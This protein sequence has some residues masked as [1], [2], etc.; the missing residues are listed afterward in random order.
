MDSIIQTILEQS[1]RKSHKAGSRQQ[2]FE[3][4]KYHAARIQATHA[5]KGAIARLAEAPTEALRTAA[6]NQITRYWKITGRH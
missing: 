1:E 3:R 2:G 6:K 4:R 5:L